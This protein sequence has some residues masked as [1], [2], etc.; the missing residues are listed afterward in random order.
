[1]VDEAFSALL[2]D[3]SNRGL[4]KKVCV[5]LCGEFS[6]TP[7]MN[8]GGNGGPPGSMGEPGRDHWGNAMFCLLGGG[9][10]KGGRVVGS[11]NRLGEAPK[12]RPLIPADIHHTMYHVLGVDRTASFI[13][14]A[15]RP[16]PALEPGEVITE[17][18]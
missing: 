17:L 13:N 4:D 5:M 9:G 1:M 6:R 3:L 14:H 7:R 16:V 2:T 10:I 12:D 15:G 18:L 11:T 8:D